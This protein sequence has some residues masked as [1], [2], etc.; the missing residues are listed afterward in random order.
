MLPAESPYNFQR[1]PDFSHEPLGP[2]HIRLLHVLA[3]DDPKAELVECSLSHHEFGAEDLVPYA[4]L[5]YTWGGEAGGQYILLDGHRFYARPHL[6]ASLKSLRHHQLSYYIWIDAICINQR[7]DEEKTEQLPL[8]GQ[9]Y[10]KASK[11]AISLH[12]DD[13]DGEN[14]F[15]D[16][17]EHYR[18]HYVEYHAPT[19][20]QVPHILHKATQWLCRNPYFGRMW[21]VQEN[22]LARERILIGRTRQV[23]WFYVARM[24]AESTMTDSNGFSQE[25]LSQMIRESGIEHAVRPDPHRL[26]QEA[27]AITMFNTLAKYRQQQCFDRRDKVFGLLGLPEMQKPKIQNTCRRSGYTKEIYHLFLDLLEWFELSPALTGWDQSQLQRYALLQETLCPIDFDRVSCKLHDSNGHNALPNLGFEVSFNRQRTVSLPAV[28]AEAYYKGRITSISHTAK[29]T[30]ILNELEGEA[31]DEIH[32]ENSRLLDL[33]GPMAP[34]VQGHIAGVETEAQKDIQSHFSNFPAI[35]C[36]QAQ[37]AWKRIES[38]LG[39]W[40]ISNTNVQVDD[41]IYAVSVGMTQNKTPISHAF[42]LREV[43][44]GRYIAVS[45]TLDHLGFRSP[46]RQRPHNALVAPMPPRGV[47]G[48]RLPN[49]QLALDPATAFAITA[50]LGLQTLAYGWRTREKRRW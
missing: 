15:F 18:Q 21:I 9:I 2:G 22:A 16:T 40:G 7:D 50:P 12:T 39:G 46:D 47:K 13:G 11:V 32:E 37:D 29:A 20:N 48:D 23:P 8:M 24:V 41:L 6:Y 3:D 27:P 36:T 44:Q 45:H 5:S 42:V 35:A 38:S 17:V 30:D 34:A 33:V 31:A 43:K 28:V 1:M 26:K 49:L 14:A 10:S 4:A 19:V 25:M